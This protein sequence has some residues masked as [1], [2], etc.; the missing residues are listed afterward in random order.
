MNEGI[1]QLEQNPIVVK[2][3]GD[4]E[5]E[6]KFEV[7]ENLMDNKTRQIALGLHG[8]FCLMC[9]YSRS[10]AKDLAMIEQG[11][12]INRS[13]EQIKEIFHRLAEVDDNGELYVP[14]KANDYGSRQGVTG[15]PLTNQDLC[16]DLSPLHAWLR[17]FTF[18]LNLI[19]R[20]VARVYKWGGIGTHNERWT[21][22]E[23]KRFETAKKLVKQLVRDHLKLQIDFV[24][25]AGGGSTDTGPLVKAF[26]KKVNRDKFIEHCL[27]NIVPGNPI[28]EDEKSYLYDFL[29]NMNVILRILGSGRKCETDRLDQFCKKT[30][31]DLVRHFPW[32]QMSM[33]AHMVLAHTTERII[34]NDGFG[35]KD[36]SE[37][38]L[39]GLHKILRN[40]RKD[41][42]RKNSLYLQIQDVF[43]FMWT[44][45]D[46]QV[47][48]MRRRLECSQCLATS[49]TKRG[50]PELK[51]NVIHDEDNDL[52]NSL[53]LD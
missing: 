8:A 45:S 40:V 28:T 3:E 42:S 1:E 44:Q 39:E 10:A 51:N 32:V 22:A 27:P 18:S 25:P 2:Y 21:T 52:V 26:Y 14:R 9:T 12:E 11:F 17:C 47:R 37:Q 19:Y 35:L 7:T 23:T 30:Y 36:I 29:Q 33:V 6:F 43:K 50:C 31:M 49:H 48:A 4:K 38:G 53:L 20:L 34:R 16:K 15:P 13:L 46:P 24:L 5:I 41:L